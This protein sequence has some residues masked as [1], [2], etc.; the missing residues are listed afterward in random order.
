MERSFGRKTPERVIKSYFLSEILLDS[1]STYPLP[2]NQ[3]KKKIIL[4]TSWKKFWESRVLLLY[5]MILKYYIFM[6]ISQHITNSIYNQM[7][8]NILLQKAKFFMS[9]VAHGT[10]AYSISSFCSVLQMRVF[11]ATFI[12]YGLASSRI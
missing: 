11:D 9:P 1:N 12:Q 4:Q 6:S 7:R 10:G 3:I 8:F 2:Q 5:C